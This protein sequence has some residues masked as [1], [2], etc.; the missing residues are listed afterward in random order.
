V[1]YYVSM[2]VA[3][4]LLQEALHWLRMKARLPPDEF[5]A[6][7]RAKW[8]L[9]L[10]AFILFVVVPV[11]AFVWFDGATQQAPATKDYFLFGAAVPLVLKSS[12]ATSMAADSA[13]KLGRRSWMRRYLEVG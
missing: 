9:A 11:L 5:K 4:A 13:V 1:V 6:L 3:G 8:E 2:C 7:F 12:L 10:T